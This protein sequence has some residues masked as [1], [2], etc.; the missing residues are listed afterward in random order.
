MADLVAPPEVQAPRLDLAVAPFDGQKRNF[1]TFLRSL[2]LLFMANPT[3]YA[4]DLAKVLFA[5]SKITGEGFAAEWANMKAEEILG[6]GEAGTWVQFVEEMKRA[7]DDPNDRA[8]ALADI[9]RLKQGSMTA[10][11]FFAKF[12]TLF[13]QAEMTEEADSDILVHWLELNLSRRLVG[14]VYGVSPMPETYAEWKTLVER[15]DAQQRRFDGVIAQQT[16]ARPI[17]L[18]A[19]RPLPQPYRSAPAPRPILAQPLARTPVAPTMPR[20]AN[21]GD[22]MVVDR[23]RAPGGVRTCFRCGQAGHMVR[24]CPFPDMRPQIPRP[25]VRAVESQVRGTEDYE[26]EI[27][28]LRDRLELYEK[29]RKAPAEEQDFGDE[30]Q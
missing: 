21:T 12:E 30:A 11:E 23:A 20:P 2:H 4:T 17:P 13:R 27:A 8:T 29:E 3:V 7:F 16:Q 5:L 19:N 6:N 24:E 15:L 10:T 14:K 18:A 22:A 25:Q 26:N 28:L 9:A 1:R